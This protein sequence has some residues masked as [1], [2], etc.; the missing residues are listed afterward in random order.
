MIT[1]QD[2]FEILNDADYGLA[3]LEDSGEQGQLITEM[4]RDLSLLIKKLEKL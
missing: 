1:A 3:M 2:I 4:R